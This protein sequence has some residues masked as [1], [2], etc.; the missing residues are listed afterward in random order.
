MYDV[1]YIKVHTRRVQ[2]GIICSQ[3]W[4]H[5]ATPRRVKKR[6]ARLHYRRTST[7]RSI[8]LVKIGSRG[9]QMYCFFR[10]VR[11]MVHKKAQTNACSFPQLTRTSPKPSRSIFRVNRT[12]PAPG[13][14]LCWR[15]Q[16]GCATLT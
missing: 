7:C 10:Y 3:F 15:C 1:S 11:Y 2:P 8:L 14:H 13:A 5:G 16:T 4:G 6:Y 9:T 12:T